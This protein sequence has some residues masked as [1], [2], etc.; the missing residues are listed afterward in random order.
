M[1]KLTRDLF[2]P[3]IDEDALNRIETDEHELVKVDKTTIFELKDSEG[4]TNKK[5][6]ENQHKKQMEYGKWNEIELPSN[7]KLAYEYANKADTIEVYY[8]KRDDCNNFIECSCVHD[9]TLIHEYTL[10]DSIIEYIANLVRKPF[11]IGNVELKRE[12]DENSDKF[13]PKDKP[14]LQ[15]RSTMKVYYKVLGEEC[16]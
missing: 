5:P 16:K 2:V 10:V 6:E 1:A 14:Y 8:E 9:G 13:A 3:Y 15:E 12:F 7:R 11:V 4:F